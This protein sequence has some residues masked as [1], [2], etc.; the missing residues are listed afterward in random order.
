M[1]GG[2]CHVLEFVPVDGSPDT[3]GR[4]AFPP[5]PLETCSVEPDAGW[6]VRIAVPGVDALGWSVDVGDGEGALESW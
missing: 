5:S 4:S 2:A 6:G 3:T 1:I